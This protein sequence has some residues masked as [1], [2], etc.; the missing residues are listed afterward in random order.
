MIYEGNKATVHNVLLGKTFISR[1][2]VGFKVAMVRKAMKFEHSYFNE[3]ISNVGAVRQ[4]RL[5]FIL[6]YFIKQLPN[7]QRVWMA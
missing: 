3:S 6:F 2:A 4:K 1:T 5:N 7:G